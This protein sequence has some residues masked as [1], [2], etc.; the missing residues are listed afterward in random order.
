MIDGG[1]KMDQGGKS[2]WIDRNMRQWDES[3]YPLPRVII[4]FIKRLKKVRIL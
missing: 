1:L 4:K 3:S 2:G